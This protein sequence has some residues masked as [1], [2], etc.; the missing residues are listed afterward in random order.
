MLEFTLDFILVFLTI[1][2]FISGLLKLFSQKQFNNTLKAL[3]IIPKRYI[4]LLGVVLPITEIFLAILIIFGSRWSMIMGLITSF[5]LLSIFNVVSLYLIR[6]DQVN[7]KCSCF[8]PFSHSTFDRELII[9][10]ACLSILV[11]F[12]LLV[13]AFDLIKVQP[14]TFNNLLPIVFPVI[15]AYLVYA[16]SRYFLTHNDYF[17]LPNS[18]DQEELLRLAQMLNRYKN[19]KLDRV[20]GTE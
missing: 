13:F 4:S 15:G 20:G 14:R 1:L 11:L 3:R 19:R 2:F 7:I 16:L 12:V 5:F 18:Y 17:Y 9:R 8:G 6:Q 10:N